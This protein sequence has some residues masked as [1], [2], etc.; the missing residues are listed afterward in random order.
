[1]I[2]K[3]TYLNATKVIF[4][5]A[6]FNMNKG[7]T[8]RVIIGMRYFPFFLNLSLLTCFKTKEV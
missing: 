3:I 2:T 7:Q 4:K 8:L 6:R 1:M 5:S